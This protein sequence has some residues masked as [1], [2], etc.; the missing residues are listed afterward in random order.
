[1]SLKRV[2]TVALVGLVL[3]VS[4]WGAAPAQSVGENTG[5][6]LSAIDWL[7]DSVALPNEK[8]A[9]APTSPMATLAP[10]VTVA[11]LDTPVP[12]RAGLI[13]AS[14][15]GIPVDIWGGSTAG[16]LA[17]LV[18]SIPPISEPSL[19]RLLTDL[20]IARLDPPVDAIADDSL[21]LARLDKLLDLGQLDAAQALIDAAGA[22][23]PR[24]FRRAFDIA[25]LK[26]TEAR[27]CRAIKATPDISPTFPTRI[28]CL[29][30]NGEWDVAALTLGT[31]EALGIL[32]EDEDKLLLHFLD[33][34]LFEGEPIPPAPANMSP[35][36]FRLYEA[37]GERPAT[38]RL[39]VAFAFADLSQTV[40]WKTRLRAAERL[41][42][43]EALSAATLMSVFQERKAA[44]SGG[45][46][47]RVKAYQ[48]VFQANS[49]GD[50]KALWNALPSAWDAAISTGSEATL[51][52][53][54]LPRLNATK[55]T[56]PARQLALEIA[57]LAGDFDSALEF[58]NDSSED[59]TLVAVA[60]G[61]PFN[62]SA[63]TPLARAIRRSLS[64]L[65][66]SDR[67]RI[68]MR[69]G[70]TG[71]ALLIAITVLADGVEGDPSALGDALALLR[72]INLENVARRI[73]VELL[74]KE[75]RI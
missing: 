27:S 5:A 29:A 48:S 20:L 41:A 28:F 66:P 31:A 63:T 52:P 42:A 10:R 50:Y 22:P 68:H 13:T 17:H 19:R 4:N 7:S 26:G 71:E 36:V 1:M 75:S 23:E 35:L 55:M 11:T 40:G 9:E 47:E 51:A 12:D 62:I 2:N 72:S 32:T 64:G 34:E 8:P 6:P 3:A 60:A 24:R 43:T 45:L 67:Y 70:R 39:P 18:R 59:Q 73:A 74:I 33:P 30:R 57:L 21:Y 61:K 25:L 46:W 69:D 16:E 58:A 38:D 65:P 49:D 37:V 14:D 44:A 53:W 56:G 54:L 15:I